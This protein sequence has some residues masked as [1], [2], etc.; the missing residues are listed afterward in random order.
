M[1][2]ESQSRVEDGFM[3]HPASVVEAFV[4]PQAQ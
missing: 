3:E 1:P 2:S 4:H